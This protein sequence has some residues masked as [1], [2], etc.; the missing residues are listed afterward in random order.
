MDKQYNDVK[1]FYIKYDVPYADKPTPMPLERALQ[2][3]GW[4]REELGEFVEAA[5]QGDLVEQVDAMIDVIYFALGNLVEMGV[6]P[7]AIWDIVHTANMSKDRSGQTLRG[8][9]GKIIKPDDWV[10]PNEGIQRV[11]EGLSN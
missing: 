9:D 8:P 11:I 2:R 10:P 5:E 1:D 4:L 3:D 6:P 7:D